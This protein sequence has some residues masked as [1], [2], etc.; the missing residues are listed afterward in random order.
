MSVRRAALIGNPNCGKTTLFNVL[1]G[2]RQ[3]VGNWPGV[4][5]ERKQGLFRL[6]TGEL[7]ELVDLPGIYSLEQDELALDE[8][9]ARDFLATANIDLIINVLDASCLDRQLLLTHQLRDFGKA[10]LVVVNMMDV[11]TS[12]GLHIDLTKLS[13]SIG[14][15]VI[16]VSATHPGAAS[17]VA[18]KIDFMPVALA[19]QQ[20]GLPQAPA[21]RTLIRLQQVRDWQQQAVVEPAEGRSLSERIDCFVLHRWLGV[22]V[23]LVAMYLLFT[24]AINLGSV[25][26]DFF[27]ILGGAWLVDGVHRLL[28]WGGAPAWLGVVLAD[29]FGGGIQLVLTFVPVIGFL[30]LGL[31]LLEESGYIVRAAFVV[32]RLMRAIGLPGKAFVPLIVGFGC[33]VPAVMAT[34]TLNKESDRLVTLAMAPFISCGAR[35]PVYALFA[36]AM[37]N[38]AGQNIVFLLYLIGIA[39]AVFTGWLFRRALF[40]YELNSSILELPAYHVPSLRNILLTTWQRLQGFVQ[41]AGKTIVAVVVVLSFLNSWGVDGSFGHEDSQQSVLSRVSQAVTPALAPLG[42]QVDNWPATV[43]II[44]GIFAKEAVVGTLD[45]LYADVSGEAN[46]EASPVSLL[47]QTRLAVV[48]VWLN[49]LD[50]TSAITDPLGIRL[51]RY[52]SL[53]EAADDQQIR[54]A[55]LS[56][57]ASL[58]VTPF[59][60]FCYLLLILLYTP[61]VAAMGAL[62]RE[63]GHRWAWL[64]ISWSSLLAYASAVIVYQAGTLL[65]HPVSSVLWIL[66]MVVAVVL[67]YRVLIAIGWRV[68]GQQLARIIPTQSI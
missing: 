62:V 56:A 6:P 57:M 25:F 39:A 12:N 32:D 44:T 27:D 48:S 35:L 61:C 23:F 21:A 14:C 46:S 50:L 18:S 2:A 45:A 22:P 54:R 66:S 13:Q 17:L 43:G 41:R 34:R 11:A 52:D 7:V 55:T 8:S 37:F 65:L 5:V 29:G 60:A 51:A 64:V 31:A 36:A 58:F 59:A 30:Y 42:V 15:T 38:Q 53:D 68:K 1:T 24:V 26:I 63:A 19:Q 67:F 28:A 20:A 9:I 16:G 40:R 33:N 47:Q 49:A 10:L 4:T 3:K